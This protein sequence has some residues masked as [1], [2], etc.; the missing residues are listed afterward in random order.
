[1]SPVAL[2]LQTGDVTRVPIVDDPFRIGRDPACDLC[3]WDLRVSRRHARVVRSEGGFEL[4]SEGRHG[5]YVNG[6]KVPRARLRDGDEVALTP[7]GDPSPIVLRFDNAMQG[8]ALDPGGSLTR[9]WFEREKGRAGP[10]LVVAR[11]EVL[12]PLG[13]ATGA[14]APRLARHRTTGQDVVLSVFPPVPVGAAA[15]AW[16]RFVTAVAGPRIPR[17]RTSSTEAW[18]PSRRAP[19]G[20]S[21]PRSSAGDLPWSA[22]PRERKPRS[23]PSDASAR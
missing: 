9:A 18:T 11:Y 16:L 17:S 8:I 22:S 19:C 7:P 5:I 2:V 14:S 13:G 4:A 3:L 15:D 1:M 21:S 6:T 12:G 20:G 23:P 10:P